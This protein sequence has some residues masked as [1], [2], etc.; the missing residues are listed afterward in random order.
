M[1]WLNS[2]QTIIPSWPEGD[3]LLQEAMEKSDKTP[4]YVQLQQFQNAM[5]RIQEIWEIKEQTSHFHAFFEKF[6]V[7]DCVKAMFAFPIFWNKSIEDNEKYS[8]FLRGLNDYMMENKSKIKKEDIIAI[9][10]YIKL[11]VAKSFEQNKRLLK[12]LARLKLNI[13]KTLY[14]CNGISDGF[15]KQIIDSVETCYPSLTDF[16][17]SLQQIATFDF[18][19]ECEMAAPNF[20]KPAFDYR[21][22]K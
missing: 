17:D 20:L 16:H 4:E 13:D 8:S 18:F 2:W 12:S 10:D 1:S 6:W 14:K 21:N 15:K 7:T 3:K 9:N 19:S 5:D 22:I 11:Q